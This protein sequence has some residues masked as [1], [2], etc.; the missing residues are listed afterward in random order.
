MFRIG[1]WV[2]K[3]KLQYESTIKSF[4]QS[5]VWIYKNKYNLTEKKALTR[6]YP[7][8]SW[9]KFSL[10]RGKYSWRKLILICALH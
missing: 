6:L 7:K 9:Q 1:A 2:R 8:Q 10:S 5:S 3:I 4:V